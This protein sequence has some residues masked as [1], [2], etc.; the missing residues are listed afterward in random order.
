MHTPEIAQYTAAW[1][2]VNMYLRERTARQGGV[3]TGMFDFASV[4]GQG[5]L[6]R[7]KAALS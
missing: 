6:V 3:I 2:Q 5:Q 4:L 1:Q 7:W